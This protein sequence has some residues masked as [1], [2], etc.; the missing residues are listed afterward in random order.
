[1]VADT[2]SVASVNAAW[3]A[4]REAAGVGTVVVESVLYGTAH[5]QDVHVTR[6]G[7]SGAPVAF[8][9]RAPWA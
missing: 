6:S 5:T 4:I 9:S 3:V 2:W 1:M 7:S 8:G